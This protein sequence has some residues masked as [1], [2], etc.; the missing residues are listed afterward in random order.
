MKCVLMLSHQTTEQRLRPFD[1][2]I[3]MT[4]CVKPAVNYRTDHQPHLVV[5]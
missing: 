1:L 4:T 2:N 5:I 3:F